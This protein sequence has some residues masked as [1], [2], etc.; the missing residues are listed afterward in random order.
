[1]SSNPED[2]F[3]TILLVGERGT[4]V[5]GERDELD[6]RLFPDW[7]PS[8]AIDLVISNLERSA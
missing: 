3:S 4:G 1:M 2:L 6:N 5:V 7:S 8:R